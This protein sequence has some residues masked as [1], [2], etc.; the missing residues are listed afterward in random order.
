VQDAEDLVQETLL[1]AWRGLPEFEGRSSLRSW[2]YRIATN[3]CLNLLRD[4]SRRPEGASPGPTEA[5]E[6]TRWAEPTWV[7]PYPDT[8]LE[9]LPDR[10]EGPDARYETREAVSM[11]FVTG[12]QRLAPAQRAALV[13][14]D[15]LGF[16]ATE[17]AEMLGTSEASVNSALQRAR[18]AIESVAPPGEDRALPRSGERRA[19]LNRFADAFE[20]GDIDGVVA[21]LTE[22]AWSRMPPQPHE[23]Q[24]R[25]AIARFLSTRPIWD[26]GRTVT[27][28]PT[29]ANGQPAFAYYLA[30]PGDEVARAHG[31]LILELDGD[32]ISTITR[33]AV[34]AVLAHLGLPP[35]I[36]V[37]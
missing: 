22:D 21:L 31:L 17:A 10:A 2:L 16:R 9:G 3:R 29:A 4:R 35:T 26:G 24:G 18:A 14:R 20:E 5:P 30:D 34:G 25:A 36:P 12:L 33:C 6:P 27:L 8:L 11:A 19:L 1:A 23:Y 13:L 28:R 15:V 7:E 37:R 32:Q